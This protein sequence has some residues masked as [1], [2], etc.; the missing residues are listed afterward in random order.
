M[1]R[2]EWEILWLKHA[3]RDIEKKYEFAGFEGEGGDGGGDDGDEFESDSSMSMSES[4]S[5]KV[6]G[7]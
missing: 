1:T 3:T 7:A 2:Q 4:A 5:S 6:S